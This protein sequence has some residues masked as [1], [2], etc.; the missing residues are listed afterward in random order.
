MRNSIVAANLVFVFLFIFLSSSAPAQQWNAEQLE[1]WEF[2]KS[3]WGAKD[4]EK[5]MACFH[6]DYT[7]WAAGNPA[8]F[9]K[10]DRR[11]FQTRELETS[12]TTFLFLKPLSIQMHGNVAIVL[13]IATRTVRNKATD[14]ETTST[15]R[16][17]DVCLKVSDRWTWVADHGGPIPSN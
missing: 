5:A 9:N 13:Y 7:G 17:T 8:P 3:C 14:E 15:T 11:A 10:A 16:W 1:V 4:V 2:E 6:D 12:E